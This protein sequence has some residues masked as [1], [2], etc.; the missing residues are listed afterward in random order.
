MPM[1]CIDQM[2]I[3]MAM[4]PPDSHAAAKP[5]RLAVIHATSGSA[6]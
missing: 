3:P 1:K 6:V 2:P 5:T 4:A